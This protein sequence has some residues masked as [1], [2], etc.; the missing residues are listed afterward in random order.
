[1]KVN[2]ALLAM[3]K[4][5]DGEL[6]EMGRSEYEIAAYHWDWE[7]K[8]G[9][10][11][12][13]KKKSKDMQGGGEETREGDREGG[14]G[15]AA[16]LED[17]REGGESEEDEGTMKAIEVKGRQQARSI[18]MMVTSNGNPYM[19]WQTRILYYTYNKVSGLAKQ[20]EQ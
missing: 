14:G 15:W 9:R 12:R 1:M 18:H 20:V 10:W 6:K 4:F 13:G 7:K 8:G 3:P 16:K 5:T 19:N 11:G 17:A 2:E